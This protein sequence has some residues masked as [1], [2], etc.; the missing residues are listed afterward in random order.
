MT[1]KDTLSEHDFDRIEEEIGDLLFS[2]VNVGRFLGICCE[3]SLRMAINKFERR[4]LAVETKFRSEDR[5][6]HK[7]T[8]EEMNCAWNEIKENEARD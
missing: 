4:F 2:L 7:L 6:T 1:K 3:D 8:L 5:S